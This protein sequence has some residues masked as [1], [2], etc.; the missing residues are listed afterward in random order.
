MFRLMLLLDH[1]ANHSFGL[2]YNHDLTQNN[3]RI[4]SIFCIQRWVFVYILIILLASKPDN[5]NPKER[6]IVRSRDGLLTPLKIWY[7]Y[8]SWSLA[9][10]MTLAFVNFSLLIILLNR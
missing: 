4:P 6:A 3:N 7:P 5:L 8:V 10:R 2:A 1:R 9:A